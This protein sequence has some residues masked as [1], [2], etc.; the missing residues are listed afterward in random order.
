MTF[1]RNLK[2]PARFSLFFLWVCVCVCAYVCVLRA[3]VCERFS[4]SRFFPLVQDFLPLF[5]FSFAYKRSFSP[6][7][8]LAFCLPVWPLLQTNPEI[9]FFCSVHIQG[10]HPTANYAGHLRQIICG[11][12]S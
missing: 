12:Q 9:I 10:T 6:A 11:P 5:L 8:P 3:L 7:F 4:R 2:V 1:N